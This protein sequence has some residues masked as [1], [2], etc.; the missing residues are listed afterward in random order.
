MG[1]KREGRGGEGPPITNP[2]RA[3]RMLTPALSRILSPPASKC[4]VSDV[5]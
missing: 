5:V 3:A 2:H 4:K 1:G